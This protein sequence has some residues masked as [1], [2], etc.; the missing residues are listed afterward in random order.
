M[1]PF[2]GHA[3]LVPLSL[4][5]LGDEYLALLGVWVASFATDLWHI[6]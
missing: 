6:Q 3:F 1:L 5:F 4:D 2:W